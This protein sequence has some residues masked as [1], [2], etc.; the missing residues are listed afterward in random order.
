MA[1]MSRALLIAA[2]V[3]ALAG[4]ALLSVFALDVF[5]SGE[6]LPT[7][8]VALLMHLLPSFALIAVLAIAWTWPLAGGLLFLLAGA[9]VF[10]FL[11]NPFGVN[12]MLAGPL[13]LAGSLFI[14]GALSAKAGPHRRATR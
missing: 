1:R 14:G 12:L 10:L 3:V 5:G 6:P 8:V 7:V 2:K 4:I 11:S 13:L 9:A